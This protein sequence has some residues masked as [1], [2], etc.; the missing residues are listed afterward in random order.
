MPFRG[1]D[2][3]ALA[4]LDDPLARFFELEAAFD[5]ERGFLGD[6]VPLRLVSANL[7]LCPG[8]ATAVAAQVRA[9]TEQMRKRLSLFSTIV[10]PLQLLIAAVLLRRG[11][12][13]D[14]FL[15]EVER[16]RPLLRQLALRRSETYEVVAIL[17]LRI[18]NRLQPISSEQVQRMANIYVQMRRHHWFLTGPEDYPACAFL[19]GQRQHTPEQIGTRANQIYKGLRARAKLWRGN[20]LQTASNMLA[21]S[22]LEPAELVERFR[23]LAAGFN[24]A[25]IVRIRSSEYDEVAALCFLAQP[26]E[27]IIE[28]VTSYAHAIRERLR[29]TDRWTSFALAANLTFAR[30]L[31]DDPE[32][33]ALA[34]AKTLLDMQTIIAMRAAS[35]GGTA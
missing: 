6:H 28:T 35:G 2:G 30:L 11:D 7:V 32:L 14:A 9:S 8:V 15:D 17:A 4:R 20:P 16:V 18:R 1:H 12:Q 21:L 31:G 24:Q 5:A 13:P 29:W 25:G 22:P 19:V 23:L 3:Q 33:G 27:R 26:S 34:D 10:Q